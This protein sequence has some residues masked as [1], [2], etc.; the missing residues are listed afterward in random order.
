MGQ[1]RPVFWQILAVLEPNL[2]KIFRK[3][4]L[5]FISEAGIRSYTGNT[6]LHA[7]VKHFNSIKYAL[8]AYLNKTTVWLKT[9]KW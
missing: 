5:S 3:K 1:G 2:F 9:M 7:C 4:L 6:I 8:Q